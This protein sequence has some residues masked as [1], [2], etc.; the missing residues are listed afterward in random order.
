MRKVFQRKDR[1]QVTALCRH[2]PTGRDKAAGKHGPAVIMRLIFPVEK[3]QGRH[4]LHDIFVRI[5]GVPAEVKPVVFFFHGQPLCHGILVYVRI[6][7]FRHRRSFFHIKEPHLTG[8]IVLLPQPPQRK[9]LIEY[10]HK[11]RPFPAE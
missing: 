2:L 7:E 1:H 6:D 11:L 3:R 5:K 9:G 10:G 8:R 4:R